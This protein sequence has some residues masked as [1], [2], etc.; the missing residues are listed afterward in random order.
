MLIIDLALPTQPLMKE[1]KQATRECSINQ[2]NSTADPTTYW[3][4]SKLLTTIKPPTYKTGHL[5]FTNS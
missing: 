3:M 1:V 2:E 4:M 5:Q